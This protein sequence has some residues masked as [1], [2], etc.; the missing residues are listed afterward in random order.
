MIIALSCL[1]KQYKRHLPE[2]CL[3]ARQVLV[4]C[5]QLQ[6]HPKW[7]LIDE[8]VTIKGQYLVKNSEV[9]LETSLKDDQQGINLQSVCHFTADIQGSFESDKH[10]PSPGSGYQGVHSSGPLWCARP[11][12]GSMVRLWPHDIMKPLQYN[13][14]LKDRKLEKFWQKSKSPRALYAMM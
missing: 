12:K 7:S 2:T 4:R 10:P 14:V 6:V 13:F 1:L 11:Q 8:K 3:R 5:N 9:I